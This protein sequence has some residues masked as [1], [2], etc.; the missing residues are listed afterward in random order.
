MGR[1]ILFH[2]HLFKN[3]GT[4]IDEILE[5]NF[6]DKWVAKEF[7]YHPYN[8]NIS[9]VID[10]IRKEKDKIAFSSHTAR[11]FKFKELEKEGIKLIPI[12]FVRHPLIR[13][14]SAYKFEREKQKDIQAF[15][16]VLARN[17]SLKG[18]IEVRWYLPNDRQTKNFHI[19]RFS[20]MFYDEEGDELTK[21][22]K[23]LEELP[24]VGLVEKFEESIKRLEN[25]VKE[26]YPDFK[27]ENVRANVQIDPEVPLNERLNYLKKI[28]GKKFYKKFEEANKEDILFWEKVVEKY[29]GLS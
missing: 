27:V 13:I 21:A 18:Y 4:S 6:G 26:F 1:V 7:P 5:K 9:L 23:A 17:T 8:K 25:L 15:G 14:H 29:G 3:A 12:I 19:H 10:W 11:L 28:L 16:P 24:F 2:F 20:D 22:M